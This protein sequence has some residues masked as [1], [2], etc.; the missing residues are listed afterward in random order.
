MIHLSLKNPFL[1]I[2][3][4]IAFFTTSVCY[5]QGKKQIDLLSKKNA[6]QW[7]GYNSKTLPPGWTVDNGVLSLDHAVKKDTSY[8]GGLDVIYGGQEF[9]Y[10]ELTVDWKIEKGANSGIFYHVKEGYG[11]PTQMAPEYQIIDDVNFA[12]MNPGLKNYNAQFGSA[13]PDQLQDWQKAGADYAMHTA[14]ESKKV[15]HPAGEWNTTKIVVAPGRTEH[16]LN[17]VKLLSFEPGSADWQ[18][19]KK[20]GKWAKSESY[21]KFKSGYI[22]FQ[23]HGGSLS[24]KN[25]KVKPL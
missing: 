12:A 17:G 11:S 5:A 9:E 4:F 14:D 1:R 25:V 22:A 10:F 3:F 20:A 21:G 7:R 24:F 13:H 2:T 8:K 6:A 18:A 15:L 23:H 16:W 19:R